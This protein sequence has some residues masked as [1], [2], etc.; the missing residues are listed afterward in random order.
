LSGHELLLEVIPSKHTAQSADPVY[1]AI[2][3]LY[4]LGIYPEW[5]KLEP[6][7]AAQWQ[8][9]DRLIEERDPYCRGVVLLGLNATIDELRAGFQDARASKTCR[10]F[11]VGR[12]IFHE[13]SRQWLLGQIDDATLIQRVR[14]NFETLAGVWQ[15]TRK[16][17]REKAA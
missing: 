13:P 8:P 12:T 5:W 3:R 14:D 6:L 7:P 2:K 15:D 10:G 16:P 9:L 4:N 11:V 17:V 1:R